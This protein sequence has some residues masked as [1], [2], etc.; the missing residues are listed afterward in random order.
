M[1][2]AGPV[3]VERRLAAILAADGGGRGGHAYR[4][5][6]GRRELGDRTIAEHRG[7]IVK[8]TG[9]G[10]N[11]AAR[12]EGLADPG[13]ICI[14]GR[15]RADVAGKLGVGFEDLADQQLKNISRPVRV[16]RVRPEGLSL[17]L[18]RKRGREGWGRCLSPTSRHWR[19]CRFRT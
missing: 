5:A 4:I 17:T 10:V 8:T 19:C 14:S 7:R 15:V 13:G 2:P 6:F 11:L 18:A 9:D 16:F 1:E 3:R 12:L